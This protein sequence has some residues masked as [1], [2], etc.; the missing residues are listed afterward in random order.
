MLDPR[1]VRPEAP[2]QLLLLGGG[3]GDDALGGDVQRSDH[4]LVQ[5]LHSATG[6]GA[7]G[8]LLVARHTELADQEDVEGRLQGLRYLEADRDTAPR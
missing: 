4:V 3:H 7:H 5:D 2:L 6:D 1:T 8:Q